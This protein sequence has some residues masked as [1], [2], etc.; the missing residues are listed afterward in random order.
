MS[1][2]KLA[3]ILSF[4][5]TEMKCAVC[6][7]KP[8]GQCHRCSAPLCQGCVKTHA[9]NSHSPTLTEMTCIWCQENPSADGQVCAY[10][11][12]LLC[13]SWGCREEHEKNCHPSKVKK[14]P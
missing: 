11:P 3:T 13:D 9:K 10:C 14:R 1:E 6:E 5:A 7:N 4:P 8:D 2:E 12:A